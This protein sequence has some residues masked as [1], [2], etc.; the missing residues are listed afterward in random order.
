MEPNTLDSLRI[1]LLPQAQALSFRSGYSS[2]E[3]NHIATRA[4]RVSLCLFVW[5]SSVT[6]LVAIC[7]AALQEHYLQ[8]V[9]WAI[10]VVYF[11]AV[12]HLGIQS[13]KYRNPRCW[14]GCGSTLQWYISINVLGLIGG[15]FGLAHDIEMIFRAEN[16]HR[17]YVM[18]L[19]LRIVVVVQAG[20]GIIL[21]ACVIKYCWDFKKL[22]SSFAG[23][24][25]EMLPVQERSDDDVLGSNKIPL[26]DEQ[27]AT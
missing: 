24:Q 4:L 9:A 27:E 15:I 17:F 20:V 7:H 3:L 8:L 22:L 12:L 21:T 26:D 23:G 10:Y 6:L 13:I 18:P 25:H 11:G 19:W 5:H 14:C 1:T 16:K 2:A